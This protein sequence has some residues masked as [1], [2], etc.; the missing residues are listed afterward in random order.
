MEERYSET[1]DTL[2]GKQKEFYDTQQ[3]AL[4]PS[5]RIPAFP[6]YCQEAKAARAS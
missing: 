1:V 2:Q 6:W 3:L 4:N 5:C